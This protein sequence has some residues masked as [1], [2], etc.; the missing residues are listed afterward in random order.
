[1]AQAKFGM[2]GHV[3]RQVVDAPVGLPGPCRIDFCRFLAGQ[4]EEPS[5]GV[6]MVLAR[7]RALGTVLESIETVLSEAMAPQPDRPLSQC[8]ILR[9][10]GVGLPA[11]DP[12]NDLRTVGILLRTG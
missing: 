4:H 6:G 8:K 9:D 2:G 3:L 11:R 1:M 12:Q 5:L 10:A 7:W